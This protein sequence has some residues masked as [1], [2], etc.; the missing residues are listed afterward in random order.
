MITHLELK[1]QASHL[2]FGMV[3]A[4]LVYFDLINAAVLAGLTV[5]V[6]I[7]SL[8]ERSGQIIPFFDFFLKHLERK[9][10]EEGM[11]A[12]GLVFYLAGVTIAVAIFPKDIALA[13]IMILA[14]GDSVSRIVGPYGYLRHP[15]NST[16]FIEGVLAGWVAAASAA[17]FFVPYSYAFT[18]AAVAM[19]IEALDI[20]INNYKLDDNLT[21][22]VIAG[23]VM[24]VMRHTVGF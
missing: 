19:Y 21:I 24:L 6:L 9:S 17:L 15:L 4:A 5:V 16:K 11:R 12:Q 10:E 23:T 22:P 20:E 8:E 7:L 14:V 2:L 3:L 13:S 18:A 1:R